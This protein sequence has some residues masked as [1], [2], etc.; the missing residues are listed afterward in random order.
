MSGVSSRLDPV[1]LSSLLASRLCHDLINPVGALGS[2][3]DVLDDADMDQTM[4]DAATDLIRSG[5][6]KAIA[7]LKYARL[8]YGAAG[9]FG[10]EMPM[11]EAGAV[12]KELY[13]WSKAELSWRLPPGLA[14]KERVKIALILGQ[15]ASD[16]VPRG[17]AVA[18]F[19]E[20]GTIVVVAEGPRAL[21]NAELLAALGGRA[22]DLKPKF[23]PAYIAGLLARDA[24]GGVEA[25]LEGERVV[26]RAR[27]A[28]ALV[29][30]AS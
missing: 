20:A 21:L 23:A 19:D 8:A 10:A 16:C 24:G 18:V 14:P 28:S 6:S 13:N 15:A 3:L 7:L 27:L 25:A 11:E 12:L 30:A 2:G 22:D 29:R 26:M 5:G 1:A 17:G 4:R 9:G